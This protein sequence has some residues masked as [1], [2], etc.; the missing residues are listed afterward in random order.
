MERVDF[1]PGMERDDVP[2]L[3]RLIREEGVDG[4]PLSG[5]GFDVGNERG[6]AEA[7]EWLRRKRG[8]RGR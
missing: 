1:P 8:V 4:V 5:R 2:V 6:F 7:E 3:R